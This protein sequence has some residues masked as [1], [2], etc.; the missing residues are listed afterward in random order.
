MEKSLYTS[1]LRNY[2]KIYQGKVRDVYEVDDEDPAELN[3]GNVQILI[4]LETLIVMPN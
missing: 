2:K 3:D 1:N 4:P